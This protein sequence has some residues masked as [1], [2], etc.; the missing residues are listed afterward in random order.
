MPSLPGFKCED[1]EN[2]AD[3]FLDTL[4]QCDKELKS[5]KELTQSP[6]KN[7]MYLP[8]ECHYVGPGP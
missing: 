3:F 7:G 2:P 6:S 4:N 8:H 1:H 5:D